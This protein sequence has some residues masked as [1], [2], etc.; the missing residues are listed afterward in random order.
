[1]STRDV[2]F[3]FFDSP[4]QSRRLAGPE[5][6]IVQLEATERKQKFIGSLAKCS[7]STKT[8]MLIYSV[9][10]QGQKRGLGDFSDDTGCFLV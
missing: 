2:R 3:V 6:Q 7:M 4:K 1:M 5:L 9:T 8:E 10:I